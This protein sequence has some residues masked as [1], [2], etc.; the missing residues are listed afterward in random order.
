M[1]KSCGFFLF[2]LLFPF[3]NV[4]INAPF[5]SAWHDLIVNGTSP[6]TI[7]HLLNEIPGKVDVQVKVNH[8]GQDYFFPGIGS[9][10]SDD[11]ILAQYGGVAYLYNHLHVR[12]FIPKEKSDSHGIGRVITTGEGSY[13]GPFFGTFVTGKVRIRVWKLSDWPIPNYEGSLSISNSAPYQTL[14]HCLGTYTYPDFVTVQLKFTDGYVTDASGVVPL[15]VDDSGLAASLTH[16][17]HICGV[18]YS[19]TQT[20]M[21]FWSPNKNR[22]YVACISDGWG[23]SSYK[24]SSAD[25]IVRQ[26]ILSP[27]DI[28]TDYSFSYQWGDVTTGR[29]PTLIPINLD[30]DIVTVQVKDATTSNGRMFLGA[31]SVTVGRTGENFGG[32]V[33][34]Y[35]NSEI[36]L[37]TPNVA[38]GHLIYVG[39]VWGGGV[40]PVA[41]NIV[42]ITVKVIKTGIAGSSM[43]TWANPIPAP[44]NITHADVMVTCNHAQY[45]CMEGYRSNGANTLITY[46]GTSW[47]TTTLQ[48]SA[49]QKP[50][51][52]T[53]I[54]DIVRFLKI[55]KTNTSRYERSRTCASD[56]RPSSRAIGGL[57]GAGVLCFITAL[58]FIADCGTLLRNRKAFCSNLDNDDD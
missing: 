30:N 20:S 14:S 17:E 41:V 4:A 45:S 51:N 27:F 18:V 13:S 23:S 7:P 22:D 35:T 11:D 1:E 19:V 28:H 9:G 36:L 57:L 52:A 56:P 2:G 54:E 53:P 31:G 47:S 44:S 58:I 26:W 39:G 40:D 43:T 37:W 6:V 29:V 50:V 8:G 21:T 10:Q 15:T 33:Y 55:S 42:Q 24:Y 38:E 32:I 25:I 49:V 5:L 46:D 34:G 48:C 16:T 3:Q 12:V